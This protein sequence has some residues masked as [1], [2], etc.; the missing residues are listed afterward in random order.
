MISRSQFLWS[1]ALFAVTAF[2]FSPPAHAS[3]GGDANSIQGDAQ[4][5]RA[6]VRVTQSSNYSVQEM[7]VAG[8]TVRE[9][10]SGGKVFAV[11]WQGAARPD[12]QQLLGPYYA[13]LTQEVQ[14]DKIKHPGRHP[15]SIQQSDLVVQM[16]GH[17]RAFSG[18]AY[19]PNM[20]PAAVR[21]E[22]IR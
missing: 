5:L 9:Y 15:I 6:T 20:M 11:T 17:Q 16:G 12:L 2:P 18:R 4:H 8:A 1:I 21:A 7:Q 10:V 13:R 22:E 3:L 19:V 14:A